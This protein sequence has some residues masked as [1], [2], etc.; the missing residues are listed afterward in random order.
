MHL[1]K[2]TV[3]SVAVFMFGMLFSLSAATIKVVHDYSNR[4]SLCQKLLLAGFN[5][6]MDGFKP[7]EGIAATFSD[8]KTF[9]CAPHEGSTALLLQPT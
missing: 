2:K 6:S 8:A 1:F 4:V 3:F 5:H 7:A 9:G